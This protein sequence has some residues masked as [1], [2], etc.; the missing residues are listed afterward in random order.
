MFTVEWKLHFNK[1][2]MC[3]ADEV[4]KSPCISQTA[5]DPLW[6]LNIEDASHNIFPNRMVKRTNFEFLI[7]LYGTSTFLYKINAF[8]RIFDRQKIPYSVF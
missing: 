8:E 2:S 5:I 7:T 1:V 4:L 3:K 6:L